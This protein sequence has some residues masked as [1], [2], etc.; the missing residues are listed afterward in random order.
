[1]WI[2]LCA[3][4]LFAVDAGLAC[5]ALHLKQKT[6]GKHAQPISLGH[7]VAASLAALFVHFLASWPLAFVLNMSGIPGRTLY[8]GC[9]IFG[10]VTP[11][12][13]FAMIVIEAGS[14][15]GAEV[16]FGGM[17]TAQP[18]PTDFSKAHALVQQDD[19]DG[20]LREYRAHFRENPTDPRPLF[21]A[22]RLLANEHRWSDAADAFRDIIGRFRDQDEVWAKASFRLA[23]I[24][25]HHLDEKELAVFIL[26]EIAR[27]MPAEDPGRRARQ[28]LI[29]I[30]QAPPKGQIAP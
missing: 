22:A 23:E 30:E 4:V 12:V 1:M 28:W 6:W 2:L 27:R 14:R 29:D 17:K 25:L 10:G 7:A 24:C 13:I 26:N 9:F 5:L 18:L 3:V 19:V 21:E 8:L 15:G 11:A 16:L 20:A